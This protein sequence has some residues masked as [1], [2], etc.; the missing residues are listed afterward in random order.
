MSKYNHSCCIALYCTGVNNVVY[1]ITLLP[2]YLW[3]RQMFTWQLLKTY[4]GGK[5]S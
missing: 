2:P 5:K 4:S 1:V 3:I